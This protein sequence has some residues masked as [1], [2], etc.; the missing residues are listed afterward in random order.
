MNKVDI[1]LTEMI[2][3][4]A[5]GSR[6]SSIFCWWSS[7]RAP[8]TRASL[9]RGKVIPDLTSCLAKVHRHI[10]LSLLANYTQARVNTTVVLYNVIYRPYELCSKWQFLELSSPFHIPRSF[11][12][13]LHLCAF[14]AFY[15]ILS[16]AIRRALCIWL[17]TSH[18]LTRVI[19]LIW[20]F[21]LICCCL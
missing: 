16:G 11:L 4:E 5:T 10:L 13:N 6:R 9:D 18:S 14:G 3:V 1:D 20:S 21:H 2:M 7:T 15:S 12:I 8:K 19:Q 17:D